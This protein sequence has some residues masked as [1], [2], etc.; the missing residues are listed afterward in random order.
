MCREGSVAPVRQKATLSS[1]TGEPACGTW[2]LTG[3]LACDAASTATSMTIEAGGQARGVASALEGGGL[4][5]D[6]AQG[7]AG[8]VQE[9]P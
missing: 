9:R 6:G 1:S 5:T 7:R 8:L 4:T 3:V 2:Y